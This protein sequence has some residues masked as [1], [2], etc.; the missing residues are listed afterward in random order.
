MGPGRRWIA[1]VFTEAVRQ[2]RCTCKFRNALDYLPRKADNNSRLSCAGSA[3]SNSPEARQ[4]F[5]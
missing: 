3:V 5:S 1:S 2:Q 4:E